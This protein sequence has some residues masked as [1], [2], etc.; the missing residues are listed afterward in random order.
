MKVNQTLQNALDKILKKVNEHDSTEMSTIALDLI[1]ESLIDL[2]VS[3]DWTELVRRTDILYDAG[4]FCDVCIEMPDLCERILI[5]K[6]QGSDK[7]IMRE[8]TPAKFWELKERYAY[9]SQP[10]IYT[11]YNV[12]RTGTAYA[13]NPV[14]EYFPEAVDGTTFELWYITALDKLTASD[15]T[16][17]P[18]IPQNLWRLAQQN[19]VVE[20]MKMLNFDLKRIAYEEA[21]LAGLLEATKQRDRFGHDNSGDISRRSDELGHILR[22]R[23]KL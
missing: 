19:T 10:F 21:N 5:L 8:C 11:H 3:H 22:R 16:K 1:N 7:P 6:E 4:A 13:P 23:A 2:V 17:V 9:A 14:I 12:N 20:M 15:L 18:L